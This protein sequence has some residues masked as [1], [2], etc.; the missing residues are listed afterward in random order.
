MRRYEESRMRR[1]E[2]L[3]KWYIKV[4]Q[5]REAA[6][7]RK[8]ICPLR[9]RESPKKGQFDAAPVD[10]LCR[11]CVL[12][13]AGGRK[14]AWPGKRRAR[15]EEKQRK[16]EERKKKRHKAEPDGWKEADVPR[17]K[18]RAEPVEELSPLDD[19][20]TE[21]DR[22]L[23]GAPA[24]V[25]PEQETE[26]DRLCAWSDDEGKTP[27]AQPKQR[28][29]HDKKSPTS[30]ATEPPSDEATEPPSEPRSQEEVELEP[31]SMVDSEGEAAAAE[32]LL[33][34]TA[35]PKMRARPGKSK[36]DTSAVLW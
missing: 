25:A 29:R 9:N 31:T 27:H 34:T 5:A 20:E 33:V 10:G 36:E 14:T 23:A 11:R 4:L 28:A 15:E 19:D 30:D 32:N 6:E 17:P 3:L 26:L 8:R 2:E 24:V 21:L 16:E 18:Q 35:R 13:L 22:L 12:L 1:E 7:E